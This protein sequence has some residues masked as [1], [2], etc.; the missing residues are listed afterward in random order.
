HHPYRP[1]GGRYDT[2]Q[3]LSRKRPPA[4]AGAALHPPVSSVTPGRPSFPPYSAGRQAPQK[5]PKVGRSGYGWANPS[6]EAPKKQ[7]RRS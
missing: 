7:S 5:G 4:A 2:E 6:F 1:G 3:R